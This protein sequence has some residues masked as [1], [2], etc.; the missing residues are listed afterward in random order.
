MF[1]VN[2]KVILFNISNIVFDWTIIEALSLAVYFY[3]PG[4]TPGARVDLWVIK[5]NVN[6]LSYITG[7]AFV[8]VYNII[9]LITSGIKLKLIITYS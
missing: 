6:K 8:K 5:F 2:I 9:N 3:I 7:D 4:Y 1:K